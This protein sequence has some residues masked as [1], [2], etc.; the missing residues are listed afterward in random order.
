MS[1]GKKFKPCVLYYTKHTSNR[2][3]LRNWLIASSRGGNIATRILP[4]YAK[5]R[6]PAT[7]CTP[8]PGHLHPQILKALA[9]FGNYV[10]FSSCFLSKEEHFRRT[11]L[12]SWAFVDKRSVRRMNI[13]YLNPL[14]RNH[15]RRLLS[16]CISYRPLLRRQPYM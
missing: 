2:A 6:G 16:T 13:S 10:R 7:V 14:L 11:S 4:L 12:P 8:S 15:L 9:S 5:M 1:L 3:I